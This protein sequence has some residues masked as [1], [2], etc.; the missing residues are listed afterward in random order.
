MRMET[1]CFE[2]GRVYFKPFGAES[3]YAHLR[4]DK[5]TQDEEEKIT[6]DIFLTTESN[7][8]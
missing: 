1:P 7:S 3:V 4:L 8:S 5:D 2:H 6:R